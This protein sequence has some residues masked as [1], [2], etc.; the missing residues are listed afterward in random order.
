MAMANYSIYVF[1]G[2]LADMDDDEVAI[3]LGHELAHA[4]HEH[5]RRRRSRTD[6]QLAAWP[7]SMRRRDR[8][9][10]EAPSAGLAILAASALLPTATAAST[11]DQADRVGLRYAY[12]AGYD[13]T[14]GPHLWNRFAEKYGEG[15]MP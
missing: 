11:E 7:P 15:S 6:R 4:T 10:H 5:S 8:Q 9:Q 1:T 2:L 3:V 12:E 13:V 14:K